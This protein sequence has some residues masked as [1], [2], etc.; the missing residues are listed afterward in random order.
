MDLDQ[1]QVGANDVMSDFAIMECPKC[2]GYGVLDSGENCT[3]CGGS[4]SGGLRSIDGCIGS[5]EIITD[6]STG[7]QISAKEMASRLGEKSA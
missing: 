4:G 2:H 3:N 5:G 1:V 7:R 6:K